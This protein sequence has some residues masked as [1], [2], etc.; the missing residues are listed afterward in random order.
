MQQ[1]MG[2]ALYQSELCLQSD[3]SYPKQ[4]GRKRSSFLQKK[5]S[6]KA[7]FPFKVM[8]QAI[9]ICTLK[10]KYLNLSIFFIVCPSC[11]ICRWL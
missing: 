7:F 2:L 6:K 10:P 11:P 8:G 1:K 3:Q 4:G 9:N 5:L